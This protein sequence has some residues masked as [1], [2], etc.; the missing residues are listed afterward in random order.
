MISESNVKLGLP[1]TIL[2]YWTATSKWS[3]C[4]KK[5]VV[6]FKFAWFKFSWVW[7]AGNIKYSVSYADHF[8]G[9]PSS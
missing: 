7:H 9:W 1:Q 6:A 2:A 5:T 8:Y 3:K 4:I